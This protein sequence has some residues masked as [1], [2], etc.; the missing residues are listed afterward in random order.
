MIN[1][2]SS[3]PAGQPTGES[4]VAPDQDKESFSFSL[5]PEPAPSCEKV[6]PVPAHSI[7]DNVGFGGRLLA[8]VKETVRSEWKT[9]VGAG[10]VS[11]VV[12]L[13]MRNYLLKST[14]RRMLV[15]FIECLNALESNTITMKESQ[16]RAETI[17]RL[18]STKDA[19]ASLY[20]A[21]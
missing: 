20:N 8:Q 17:N 4:P 10:L 12:Y 18:R 16:V 19:L 9:V 3:S 1:P 11:T 14:Y 13:A 15:A 6:P 7:R 5:S 21:V 2:I